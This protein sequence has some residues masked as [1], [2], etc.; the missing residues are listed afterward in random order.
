M[1]RKRNAKGHFI[2]SPKDV[3]TK[4]KPKQTFLSIHPPQ[5]KKGAKKL[6][7]YEAMIYLDFEIMAPTAP[8]RFQLVG[9]SDQVEEALNKMS[10]KSGWKLKDPLVSKL[11]PKKKSKVL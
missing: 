4:A 8:D 1:E 3:K 10:L 11:Y 6:Y 7:Q 2:K 5:E 9:A